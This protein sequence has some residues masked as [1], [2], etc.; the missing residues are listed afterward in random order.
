MALFSSQA[1]ALGRLAHFENG[2]IPGRSHNAV[3]HL[4]MAPL[5]YKLV[6]YK[7]MA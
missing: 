6:I 3:V 2:N 4:M 7:Y 5:I 1:E